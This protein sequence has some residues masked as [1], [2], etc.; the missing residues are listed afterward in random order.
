MFSDPPTDE[1]KTVF[2]HT[3]EEWRHPRSSCGRDE[4]HE[5]VSEPV[6]RL[7]YDGPSDSDIFGGGGLNPEARRDS[8]IAKFNPSSKRSGVL[9]GTN[10]VYHLDNEHDPEAIIEK[11]IKINSERLKSN[12]F[13]TENLTRALRS[14]KFD[15][16]WQ[17]LKEKKDFD[18]LSTP[19]TGNRGTQGSQDKK[20]PYC[21]ESVG[22]LSSHIRTDH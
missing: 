18:A 13:S 14:G 11:W 19:D 22:Q 3:C 17:N 2:C 20:C 5:T 6:L 4:S 12:D 21:G 9:G 10:A 7:R 16:A 8:P 1:N 15:S